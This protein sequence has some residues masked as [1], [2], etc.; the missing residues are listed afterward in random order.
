M[1]QPLI[2]LWRGV[3]RRSGEWVTKLH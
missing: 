2:Y 1:I 3:D